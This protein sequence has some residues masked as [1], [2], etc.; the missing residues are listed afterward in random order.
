MTS[1]PI[2]LAFFITKIFYEDKAL[3]IE[4]WLYFEDGDKIIRY[5]RSW[6]NTTI[7]EPIDNWR[8]DTQEE[9][10]NAFITLYL[11]ELN[12][13]DE[14]IKIVDKPEKQ[15]KTTYSY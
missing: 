8:Y 5:Q 12:L 9:R 3:Q 14:T 6:D 2:L 7:I 15:A 1:L 13:D 10:V 4:D 11:S